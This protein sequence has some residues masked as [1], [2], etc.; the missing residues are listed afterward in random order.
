VEKS[1]QGRFGFGARELELALED[2][3]D[4][5]NGGLPIAGFPNSEAHLIEFELPIQGHL[6]HGGECPSPSG[7]PGLRVVQSATVKRHIRMPAWL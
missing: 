3:G 1:V 7:W 6:E 4:R 2:A 5:E